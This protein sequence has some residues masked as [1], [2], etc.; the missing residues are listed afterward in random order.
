VRLKLLSHAGGQR[1]ILLGDDLERNTVR[2]DFNEAGCW[3][4]GKDSGQRRRRGGGR[5]GGGGEGGEG[6]GQ[7]EGG[8]G[9]SATKE[10]KP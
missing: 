10:T 6:D 8:E 3:L 2:H 9:N 1:E 5:R 7:E 4:S